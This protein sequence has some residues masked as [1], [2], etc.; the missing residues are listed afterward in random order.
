MQTTKRD[1]TR[2]LIRG[3]LLALALATTVV[4][5]KGGAGSAGEPG[6]NAATT[7]NDR[8]DRDGCDQG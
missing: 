6:Q 8:G 1:R 5:C 7:G 2:P 3:V 4:G